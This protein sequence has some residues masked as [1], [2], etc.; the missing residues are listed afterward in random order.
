MRRIFKLSMACLAAGLASACSNLAEVTQSPV[1]PTSGVRFINAVQDTSGGNGLDFRF[2]DRVENNVHSQIQF[3]NSPITA[4]G[5]TGSTKVEYK[6]SRAG[7]R[8]FKIFL[9]DTLQTAASTVLNTATVPFESFPAGILTDDTTLVLTEGKNYTVILWGSA[10]S[11]ATVPLKLTA[12][13][14]DVPDPTTNVALRVINATNGP[15]NATA[16]NGAT[17]LA[18]WTGIPALSVSAYQTTAPGPVTYNITGASAATLTGLAMPGDTATADFQALPGTKIA[19][20]AVSGVVFPRTVAGSR[21]AQ[22][23]TTPTM[24]FIWDRRPPK[25]CKVITG[26][27]LC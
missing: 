16:V 6:A 21:A 13:Q 4:N 27:S 10:R 14:E 3:S 23:F 7:T 19:G 9:N 22:G 20:S 1:I 11:G 25:G 17:T 18:T 2:V 5:W 12:I 8:Y 26:V 24:S 15:I